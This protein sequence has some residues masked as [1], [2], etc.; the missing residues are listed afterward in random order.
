MIKLF[1]V[2]FPG[3]TLLL[4]I[5]EG[6]LSALT[7]LAAIYLWFGN[8]VDLA[9]RYDYGALRILFAS[10]VCVLCMYYYDLYDSLVVRS[11]REVAARM[12][13]VLGTVC[14]VLAVIYYSYPAAQIGRGPML[15]WVVVSGIALLLW[16][17]GYV[18]VSTS[19]QLGERCIL[20][21]DGPLGKSLA[22]EIAARPEFGFHLAGYVSQESWVEGAADL[23]R[24]GG[25][26]EL[27]EIVRREKI[28]RVIVGMAD[29]RGHLPVQELL[30][31]KT[32]GI[33]IHD[34]PE[35]FEAVT[36]Q[37]PVRWLQA[38]WLLFS[39]GFRISRGILFYKRSLSCAVSL[40]G[41]A[42]TAPLMALVAVLIRLDSPGPVIFRQKR[43]GKDGRP[44]T[45]FKFR[46]MRE[47][48]DPA[49]P[50]LPDDER[51]TRVGRWIRRCRI[52]ELPQLFNILRGDMCLVGPR[53]FI[54][55][56]E[57]R[58]AREI[59]FY[60]QRW[61]V[62]PGATGWAQIKKGYCSTLEDNVEKLGYDL[63]YIKNISPGLDCLILLHTIKI[64]LL[65][66]GAR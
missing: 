38:S 42:L 40:C 61:S 54:P 65:G 55:E 46:S 31:L 1:H 27:P 6:M 3:R 49:R 33:K 9:L 39:G 7:L 19:A 58:Y 37:V 22:E 35:I 53:P 30:G 4:A 52:D 47:D 18:S 50:A 64:L 24:L 5:S 29:R 32:H 21:G 17:R 2:C 20:L 57:A 8:N 43:I 14:I 11:F 13:Q 28:S 25:I 62:P 26:G 48:A 36:G 45:L 15:T 66:R 10:F 41:I 34:A 16:R 56:A 60:S 63:F 12:V 59:P 23:P 51:I 44:F